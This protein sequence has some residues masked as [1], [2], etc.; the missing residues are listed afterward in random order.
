MLG[1][2]SDVGQ[3]LNR[4]F[5]RDTH[6]TTAWNRLERMDGALE[7]CGGAGHQNGISSSRFSTATCRDAIGPLEI[8]SSRLGGARSRA[9][10]MRTRS[11]GVI[12]PWKSVIT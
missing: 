7:D 10:G 1:N 3:L 2:A 6:Y 11:A 9:V 5:N 8:G 4:T 12:L